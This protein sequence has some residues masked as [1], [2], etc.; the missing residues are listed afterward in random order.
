MPGAV[1]YNVEVADNPGFSKVVWK[2]DS[3]QSIAVPDIVL[4]DG[5]YWWRVRAVDD[6]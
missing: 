1:S 2:G 4:P 3:Q 6:A 5:A